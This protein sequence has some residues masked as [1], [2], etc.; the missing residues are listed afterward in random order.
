M[1]H[2]KT[3]SSMQWW[4]CVWMST[5]T[6]D[7]RWFVGVHYFFSAH[8]R[9]PVIYGHAKDWFA[10]TCR[11]L[12]ENCW[13]VFFAREPRKFYWRTWPRRMTRCRKVQRVGAPLKPS[14][15]LAPLL[16]QC[17]RLQGSGPANADSAWHC[18]VSPVSNSEIEAWQDVPTFLR[19]AAS[20]QTWQY[21]PSTIALLSAMKCK[22]KEFLK[23]G[24]TRVYA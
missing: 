7:T 1:R 15:P 16:G 17:Q 22:V 20:R 12:Y 19:A 4:V 5:F 21:H 10:T 3:N 6:E 11:S 18:V 13:I 23:H 8:H 14:K 9:I 2:P 24:Q